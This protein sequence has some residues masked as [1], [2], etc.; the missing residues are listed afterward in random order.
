MTNLC[1]AAPVAQS[2][3]HGTRT[4]PLAVNQEIPF[5]LLWH[6]RFNDVTAAMLLP[7]GNA[8]IPTVGWVSPS[9]IGGN[10]PSSLSTREGSPYQLSN[11]KP[12]PAWF[13]P[14]APLCR[15]L[16]RNCRYSLRL[17]EVA[18]RKDRLQC[19]HDLLAL[20]A[21]SGHSKTGA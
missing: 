11:H 18:R 1:R 2:R 7:G 8:A 3:Q 19:L 14:A 21:Y 13:H 4:P 10:F 9:V 20:N 5:T 16:E 12:G 6:Q 15:F 17:P